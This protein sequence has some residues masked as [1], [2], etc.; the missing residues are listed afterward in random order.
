MR[1][2]GGK[3]IGARKSRC[4]DIGHGLTNPVATSGRD[5]FDSADGFECG[6]ES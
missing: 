3:K 6:Q 1:A 2:G 4:G 5:L